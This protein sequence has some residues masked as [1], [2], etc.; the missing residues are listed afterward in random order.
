MLHRSPEPGSRSEA[1]VYRRHTQPFP[2]YHERSAHQEPN[3]Q[4]L[5]QPYHP[6]QSRTDLQAERHD[7]SCQGYLSM[8]NEPGPPETETRLEEVGGQREGRRQ[9]R[10]DGLLRSRKAVLPSE[11]RRRERST[12]DPQRGRFEE[13]DMAM[14]HQGSS[15]ENREVMKDLRERRGGWSRREEVTEHVSR[16]QA[17]E[18]M[19]LRGRQAQERTEGWYHQRGTRAA[20]QA[21]APPVG[22]RWAPDPGKHATQNI[23]QPPGHIQEAVHSREAVPQEAIANGDHSPLDVKVSVAQLRHSYLES[24]TSPRRPEQYVMN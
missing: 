21:P 23:P 17:T 5:Y 13:M 10:A 4:L 3:I 1:P 14:Q 19:H 20:V 11:V 24:A 7:P 15:A 8:G 12:E 18:A 2:G 22:G 16:L 9:V 6:Q